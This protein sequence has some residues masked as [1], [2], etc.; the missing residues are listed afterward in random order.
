VIAVDT[1]GSIDEGMIQR[2]LSEVSVI[3]DDV[4]PTQVHLIYWDTSVCQHEVYDESDYE[5]MHQM[6][7]P[8]GGGGTNVRCV[9]DYTKDKISLESDIECMLILTD[10]YVGYL[11]EEWNNV[12]YPILWAISPD[13]MPN[14]NPSNGQV[15]QLDKE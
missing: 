1:S 3:T 4:L 13:G 7:K 11:D 15:I 9:L 6:T 2:F 12:E 14:F 5:M 10:G 8:M